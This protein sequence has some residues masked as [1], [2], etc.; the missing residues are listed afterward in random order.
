[1]VSEG[2]ITTFV[3]PFEPTSHTPSFSTSIR[4]NGRVAIQPRAFRSSLLE[5]SADSAMIPF[6]RLDAETLLL[7]LRPTRPVIRFTRDLV[8]W[9]EPT[10]PAKREDKF[11]KEDSWRSIVESSGKESDLGGGAPRISSSLRIRSTAH[12]QGVGSIGVRRH[13]CMR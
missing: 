1:M 12:V 10:R 5:K 11:R 9:S 8:L 3:F 7:S 4:E 2:P 13:A 6:S